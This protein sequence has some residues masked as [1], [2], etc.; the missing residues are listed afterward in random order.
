MELF[1][2]LESCFYL[3][4]YLQIFIF[5]VQYCNNT[6][7]NRPKTETSNLDK[8][9]SSLQI[10]AATLLLVT[11]AQSFLLPLPLELKLTNNTDTDDSRIRSPEFQKC[12]DDDRFPVGC[13]IL[14]PP[15]PGCL[16]AKLIDWIHY[17][18]TSG[19]PDCCG[20]D[21]SACRCPI[22]DSEHFSMAIEYGCQEIHT[23][24]LAYK[25]I[26]ATEALKSE[27]EDLKSE[28]PESEFPVSE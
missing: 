6:S 28:F 8:M 14:M 11:G 17:A 18:A 9:P 27:L 13:E 12:P 15:Y 26:L 4:T 22:K 21:M 23:C 7:Y 20:D 25:S 16:N 2:Q 3:L 5:Y 1:S 19:G 24:D 10:T